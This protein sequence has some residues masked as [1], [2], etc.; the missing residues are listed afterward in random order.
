MASSKELQAKLR[1][2]Q[3]KDHWLDRE[4]F[5]EGSDK[6]LVKSVAIVGFDH[7]GEQILDQA[8]IMN[9]TDRQ[10]ELTEKDR[11]YE[12][13]YWDQ[14]KDL[15]GVDY[16]VIGNDGADYCAMHPMLSEFLNLNG[17]DGGHKDSLKFYASLSDMGIRM[18]DS[19]DLIILPGG[20]VGPSH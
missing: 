17:V 4:K 3:S 18:L 7:F 13:S 5:L 6:P 11:Q 15:Q 14:L 9:V 8:L 10:L 2:R 1:R 16:F 19:I 12:G 20:R